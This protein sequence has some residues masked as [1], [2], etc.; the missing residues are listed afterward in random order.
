MMEMADWFEMHFTHVTF[1]PHTEHYGSS[2]LLHLYGG[3]NVFHINILAELR[4]EL[5]YITLKQN[6]IYKILNNI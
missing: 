3:H 2:F 5:P 1:I 6:I 4:Y